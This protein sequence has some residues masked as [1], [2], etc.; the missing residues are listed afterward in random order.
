MQGCGI[1][2]LPGSERTFYVGRRGMENCSET[3]RRRML[4]RVI[5]TEQ[6]TAPGQV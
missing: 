2:W 1:V 4:G 5:E 3:D 6:P